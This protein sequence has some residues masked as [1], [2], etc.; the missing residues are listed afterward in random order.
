MQKILFSNFCLSTRSGT[1]TFLWD[2]AR[3]LKA[4]GCDC[5]IYTPR[6]GAFAE[7][8]RRMGIP[9]WQH[10]EHI[11]MKPDVLHCQHTVESKGLIEKFPDI[12]ALFMVHDA[13]SWHDTVPEG[14]RWSAVVAVDDACCAR[15]MGETGLT[16][17]QIDVIH[18]SVDTAL[19]LPRGPLP[20]RPLKAAIFTSYAVNDEHVKTARRVCARLGIAFDELGPAAGKIVTDP[21]NWLPRYDLVFG[22]ARCALEAMAVGCAVILIGSEGVG[23]MVTPENFA[24][25]KKRNFGFSLLRP[26]LD[27]DFLEEQVKRFSAV[28]AGHV[29]ELVRRTCS[30]D[31]MVEKF[32]ELYEEL[33]A[34]TRFVINPN[35]AYSV[36]SALLDEFARMWNH[37]Q[38]C[39][40]YRQRL[41]DQERAIQN[42][43]QVITNQERAVKSYQETVGHLHQ[44][45]AE[46]NAQSIKQRERAERYRAESKK[47]KAKAAGLK[48]KLSSN[49][50]EKP[51]AWQKFWFRLKLG[52]KGAKAPPPAPFIVGSPRSGTTLLRIMLDS[53]PL[54]AIPPETAFLREI[55]K[56][57]Q[58]TCTV[59]KMVEW[60]TTYPSVHA[61]VWS[62]FHL[63][64]E[65]L[66]TAMSR[67]NP[68]TAA[69]G[70]RCFYKLYASKE[71]KPRWGDK[72]PDY[73]LHMDSIRALIPESKFIHIIRDGRDAALSL[74]A[75]PFSPGP[76][77]TDQARYWM[78]IV[79][80]G[81]RS[82]AYLG[83]CMEV[84]YEQLVSNP[85][86]VLRAVCSFLELP[87]NKAM[88]HHEE[89][90]ERR[91]LE[92]EGRVSPS[93][94]II[95]TKAARRNIWHNSARPV[96]V[97]LVGQWRLR[98]T[99]AEIAEF[100][101][102]AGSLLEELGYPLASS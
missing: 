91:L 81:R 102:V 97:N 95:L 26:D 60:I 33:P 71:K 48:T 66:K 87:F 23:E 32:R 99:S 94:E 98:I 19:L 30:L 16:P 80:A 70:V 69:E 77:M 5:G 82:A 46:L 96:D 11:T 78:S 93:G 3:G 41:H 4:Q 18:N 63:A 35:Q 22:K 58:T 38:A 73:A 24:E 61:P 10:L 8:F 14:S 40:H 34:R 88:L 100:E 85:E 47:Y 62:D 51:S 84:R 79:E 31:G 56:Q 52:N 42:Q 101:S 27:Q 92:H 59:E 43:E 29:Q 2:L 15:I 17:D 55:K 72:T 6:P 36:T 64:R 21:Q 12:P 67:L 54:L 39:E 53:H 76:T 74:R 57:T 45:L 37:H 90:A 49:K 75:Q 7:E 13:K 25:F 86:P 68:L 28:S 50:V 83:G 1:E 9:V 44:G 65:A 89:R 20:A